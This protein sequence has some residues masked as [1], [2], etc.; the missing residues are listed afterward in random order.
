M[1]ACSD[2]LPYAPLGGM[3]IACVSCKRADWDI[4][5]SS[6]GTPLQGLRLFC[7]VDDREALFGDRRPYRLHY[8]LEDSS[9]EI[10]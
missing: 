4:Q 9:C 10:L 3:G 5:D 6:R 8:F 7:L 2:A 1:L